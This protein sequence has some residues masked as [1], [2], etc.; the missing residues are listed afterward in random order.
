MTTTLEPGTP[1][2]HYRVVQPLG[3]GGMGEVYKAH[4][5]RLERM[6]ALK[7]LP[8]ALMRN[9]ERV[10]RFIQ[11]AKSASSLNHP[12]I[13]TIH[14]IGEADLPP[15]IHYM[16]M[17]FID[18]HT[19]RRKI[20][21]ERTELRALLG[22]LAQ[23][24]DGVAKAHAA[25][26]VHRDLKPDNIMVTHDGFAKVLDFG[27]AKLTVKKA[28]GEESGHSTVVR[29][30]TREGQVLGTVAYMAPEQVLGKVVDHRTDI[31]A[32][33][34]ILYE[35]ATRR[36]PFEAD[37]DVDLMHKI[38]H[39][40]PVPVDEINPAVPAEL[41]RMI[42]RCMAK[43]AD[44][45]YQSMK[46]LAIELAEIV[47]EFEE[48]SASASSAS[49]PAAQLVTQ[50]SARWL[51]PAIVF[52]AAVGVAGIAFGIYQWRRTQ[53]AAGQAVS[54]ATMKIQRLTSSANIGAAAISPDGRYL[55]HV[56]PGGDGF[57]L[58][59]RQVNTGTDVDVVSPVQLVVG[60]AFTPDGD[61]VVYSARDSATSAYSSLHQVPTLGGTPRK[62]LYDV[63]PR[64][65]YSPDGKRIVFGRG[66]PD[67]GEN[68]YLIANADG[69]QERLAYKQ[70]RF[71]LPSPPSWSPD[72]SRIATADASLEGGYHMRVVEIDVS[73]G[74]RR[75]IGTTRWDS[76]EEVVWLPAGA[77]LL[78]ARE[79][80]G[81][82]HQIWLQPHP[83]GAPSRVTNDL[84]GYF[85]LSATGDGNVVAAA[86]ESGR[87]ALELDGQPFL[88]SGNQDIQFE[89]VDASKTGSVVYD[90]ATGGRRGIG[91]ADGRGAVH[92]VLID[93]ETAFAPA[94]SDDGR[95]IAFDSERNGDVPHI[96]VVNADGSGLR[97]LTN[98]Q[99]ETTPHISPDGQTVLF[100][101]TDD[102]L[103]QVP[104]GGGQPK[105][106]A[107][108]L[109]T[110]N[111]AFS[112]DSKL[113]AVQQWHIEGT[114]VRPV[115][116]VVPLAGGPPLLD[117]L[118]PRSRGLRWSPSGDGV[119]F[120][121]GQGGAHEIYLQPLTGGEPAQLTEFGSGVIAH[122]D[123][124]PD[125]KLVVARGDLTRDLVLIRDF[126]KQS[127]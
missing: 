11:E 56:V 16:A 13:V 117:K 5:S 122:Y 127:P 97:Q 96:F 44:K 38:V 73:T 83:G 120:I 104:M 95:I 79:T 47:D 60:V 21:Q 67:I 1:V 2:S 27:L 4:D 70:R 26:I 121:G 125:G 45:R 15:R 48:L 103:W 105:K 28:P 6:V 39:D 116:R 119:T 49:G 81:A 118:L 53:T 42:R 80:I 115:L 64:V 40:K 8:L 59:I 37:S 35:A 33:G 30:E 57:H 55:A 100:V 32:M 29:D 61:Y 22:F 36:R 25:G 106:I 69:S 68:H 87:I 109:F 108:S 111:V 114:N 7:I 65:A 62:L 72:G 89:S 78:C 92:R 14:E 88:R 23:A 41:R 74:S 112:P 52:A 77:L 54:F 12:H 126:L 20:H 19:L 9:E 84:H 113:L 123:W 24:A 107:T 63:D 82:Q 58:R 102:A 94:I 18:G 75:E 98:G 34:A 46:D 10:R 85:D 93:D 91:M 43:D 76:I 66:R 110:R 86:Q 90:F 99:G 124:A 17:E 3:A 101:T 31:F 51:W 71:R 50:R